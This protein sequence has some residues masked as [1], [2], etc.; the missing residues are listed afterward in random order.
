MVAAKRD[1]VYAL[2][3]YVNSCYLTDSSDPYD[4]L[5]A[6]LQ[7]EKASCPKSI[8][9]LETGPLHKKWQFRS[10]TEKERD[11]QRG[12]GGAPHPRNTS[13]YE[14]TQRGGQLDLSRKLQ[15]DIKR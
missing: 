4:L 13:N 3:A 11:Y 5:T 12:G 6:C 7:F 9:V 1:T 15:R 10:E 8:R 2:Q 14:P